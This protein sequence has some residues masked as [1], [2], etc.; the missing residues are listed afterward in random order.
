[1]DAHASMAAAFLIR[2]VRSENFAFLAHGHSPYAYSNR[3]MGL[4]AASFDDF[5]YAH[6]SL[7]SWIL[8]HRFLFASI[9]CIYLQISLR[10]NVKGV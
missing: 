5:M 8:Y 3:Q 1:M 10:I 2:S 4:Q 9:K 7:L 6:C